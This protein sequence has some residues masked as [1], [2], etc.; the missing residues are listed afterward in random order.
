MAVTLWHN[1][2]PLPGKAWTCGHCGGTTGND[3]GYHYHGGAEGRFIYICPICNA[4]T[5][6]DKDKQV[7]SA[8]Y[9]NP[10]Q[11]LPHNVGNL[12][13][14]ARDC[15]AVNAFTA[16]VLACRKLLMNVAVS[17][18]AKDNETFVIYVNFLADKGYV[19]PNAKPWV[20]HIRQKGNEATHE[21]PPSN[22]ADAEDLLTFTEMLLKLV[23]EFPKRL[24]GHGAVP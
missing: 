12:Y 19:P 7:P 9:G 2:D 21:I 17:L 1:L 13:T 14:E 20:D 22:R 15:M 11:H 18:G 23:F 6:F 10:V 3:R 4:P 5:Y 16:A 24:P 8:A